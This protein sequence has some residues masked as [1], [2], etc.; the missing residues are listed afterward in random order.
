MPW[1]AEYTDTFGGEANY[2]WVK[3]AYFDAPENATQSAIMRRAKAAL[4]I[5][6]MR[7]ETNPLGGIEGFEFRPYR[8]CRVVF[9]SWCDYLP[10]GE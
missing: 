8:A 2:S 5:S 1:Q 9:V 6:D 4:G 7:G 3:R 10:G